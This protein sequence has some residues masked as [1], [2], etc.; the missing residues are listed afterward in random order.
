MKKQIKKTY[1]IHYFRIAA[2]VA[3]VFVVVMLVILVFVKDAENTDSDPLPTQDSNISGSTDTPVNAAPRPQEHGM[4]DLKAQIASKFSEYPGQWSA[5][6]KNLST[7]EFFTINDRQIYPAS[8]IKLFA[9][10]AVYQQIEDGMIR[11]DDYYTYIYSMVVM[12]NNVAFN[13][14]IWTIGREYL[15]KWCHDNGYT[16]TYQYHGLSPGDNAEGL[17]TSDKPNETCPSDVGKMLE[18]IYTG[19]CVSKEASEKMLKLLEQQHWVNKLPSGLPPNTHFANKTGDT[20]DQS[21]DGA[22]VFSKGADYIIVIMSENPSVSFQQDHRFIELS[23]L[24]YEYFNP[25]G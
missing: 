16:N 3:A 15:T 10:G 12:S 24:T 1:H 7:G 2:S 20:D 6:V 11:E 17:E 19:K 23:K 22:I 14:I 25:G 4:E 13:K 9:M 21:H 18:D 5:Y 8:M